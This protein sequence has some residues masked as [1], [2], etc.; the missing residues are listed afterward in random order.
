[1]MLS[2]YYLTVLS[3]VFSVSGDEISS[4]GVKL[5]RINTDGDTR[6]IFSST[7][8]MQLLLRAE[9]EFVNYIQN[10]KDILNNSTKYVFTTFCHFYLNY[11]RLDILLFLFLLICYSLFI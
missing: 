9:I 5:T 2:K 6:D 7:Y 4:E 1:M 10:N 8:Q 3:V 11:S